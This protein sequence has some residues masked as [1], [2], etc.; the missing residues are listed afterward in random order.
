MEYTGFKEIVPSEAE[1]AEL[2]SPDGVAGNKWGLL[3]NEYAVFRDESGKELGLFRQGHDGLIKVN[4]KTINSKFF[5]KVSPRN[6]QQRM[7]MDM[8][9]NGDITVKIL[10]GCYGSGKKSCSIIQ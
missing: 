5:S 6:V 10:A 1:A 7:A 2:F 8:L 3:L 4:S 9:Y